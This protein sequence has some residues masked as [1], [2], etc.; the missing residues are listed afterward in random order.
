MTWEAEQL[1]GQSLFIVVFACTGL[2]EG[3]SSLRQGSL[4]IFPLPPMTPQVCSCSLSACVTGVGS[5]GSPCAARA[6]AL[7]CFLF[8]P[9]RRSHWRWAM[10]PRRWFSVQRGIDSLHLPRA[11]AVVPWSRPC[12]SLLS[13]L[14]HV[15]SML[16]LHDG[17]VRGLPRDSVPCRLRASRRA[18]ELF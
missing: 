4:A 14:M 16:F 5:G 17:G 18:V 9:E 2:A 6:A 10:L 13:G 1:H 3:S 15:S 8:C 12:L 11:A 7:R